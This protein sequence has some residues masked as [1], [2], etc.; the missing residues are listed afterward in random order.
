ML[1]LARSSQ[2]AESFVVGWA[3]EL[4]RDGRLR[5]PMPRLGD[6]DAAAVSDAF[7]NHFNS[8]ARILDGDLRGLFGVLRVSLG[9]RIGRAG[10]VHSSRA[11]FQRI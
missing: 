1:S 11:R 10:G 8:R 6:P 7:A 3:C 9:R 5:I 4:A 2:A